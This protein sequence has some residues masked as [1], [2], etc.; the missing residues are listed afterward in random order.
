L[1]P[2]QGPYQLS[3]IAPDA[4]HVVRSAGIGTPVLVRKLVP[5]QGRRFV[6]PDSVPPV[7]ELGNNSKRPIF[8]SARGREKQP[9]R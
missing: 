2:S 8:A 6:M 7:V 9:E 4:T 1:K 5:P 3:S